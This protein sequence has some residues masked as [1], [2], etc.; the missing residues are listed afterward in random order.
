MFI[1]N[2]AKTER[3]NAQQCQLF[4]ETL[5]ADEASL[6]ASWTRCKPIATKPAP[7]NL[8]SPASAKT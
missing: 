3:M 1:R 6:Q 5:A 2:T 4:E 8:P 7:R